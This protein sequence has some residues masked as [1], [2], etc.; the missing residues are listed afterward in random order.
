[1]HAKDQVN[2]E[3]LDAVD[4]ANGKV[5][6]AKA[7][8][9]EADDDEDDVDDNQEQTSMSNNAKDFTD[10]ADLARRFEVQTIKKHKFLKGVCSH[11][12]AE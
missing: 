12:C 9:A 2:G 5:A 8:E 6:R 7:E 10:C 11:H 1:M 3:L 4:E